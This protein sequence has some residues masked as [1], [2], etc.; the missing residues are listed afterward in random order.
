MREGWLE[1]SGVRLHY[2]EWQPEGEPREPSL[3]LLHGLSSNAL[4]WGRL[5]ARLPGRRI[6]ALDQRSHGPSDRPQEGSGRD[7]MVGDA[8]EALEQLGLGRPLVVGH[9]W[10]ASVALELA[11]TRPDLA[12]GLVFVD[13]PPSPINR[14]MSWEGASERMQPP[15]P[16]YTGLDQAVEAQRRYL[17][18]EPW[19]DDLQDFVRAGLTEVEG[20][21]TSTLN[22]PVRRQILEHMFHFDPLAAFARVQGPGAAG[23]GRPARAGGAPRVRRGQKEGRRR[24]AGQPA[25]RPGALVRVPPRHPLDPAGRAG[26][27]RGTNGADGRAGQ[28]GSRGSGPRRR[29]AEARAWGRRGLGGT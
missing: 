21:L 14:V 11:A 19:G 24:S 18:D 23:D 15:F 1:R 29:L 16:I 26:D 27:G 12:S 17:G 9:P 13:G 3:F 28:P 4:V 22:V 7:G 8:A 25:R 20:G 10:G 5:A 6:V 2:L